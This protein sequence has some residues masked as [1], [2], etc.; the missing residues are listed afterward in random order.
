MIYD[1]C[2]AL[3]LAKL[4]NCVPDGDHLYMEDI[5]VQTG[6]FHVKVDFNT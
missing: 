2:K 4:K 5:G 6:D 1:A 3:K